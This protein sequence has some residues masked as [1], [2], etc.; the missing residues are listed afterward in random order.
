MAARH[1]QS[2]KS[3]LG[4]ALGR[5]FSWDLSDEMGHKQDVRKLVHA[6]YLQCGKSVRLFMSLNLKVVNGV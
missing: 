1:G 4:K 3:E 6:S 5:A 2:Q